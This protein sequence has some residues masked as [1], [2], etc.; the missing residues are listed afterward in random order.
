[1]SS[2]WPKQKQQISKVSWILKFYWDFQIMRFLKNHQWIWNSVFSSF[3]SEIMLFWWSADASQYHADPI[4]LVR[5]SI[6]I[7]FLRTSSLKRSILLGNKIKVKTNIWISITCIFTYIKG[8]NLACVSFYGQYTMINTI[9][10]LDRCLLL[11][12][13][14]FSTPDWSLFCYLIY[15]SSVCMSERI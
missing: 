9:C 13:K 4:M 12:S 10:D 7:P 8:V 14:F 15:I 2:S 11:Y 5:N 6:S 3:I 1:M